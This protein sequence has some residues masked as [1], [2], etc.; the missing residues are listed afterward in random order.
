MSD[1]VGWFNNIVY[2]LENILKVYKRQQIFIHG[3][4]NVGK[5]SLVEK[6]IGRSNLKY[7]F[8]PGLGKF[9][10]QSFD[11]H[12]HKFIVFEEFNIRFFKPSFLKRLLENRS[13]AYPV[14]CGSDNIFAFNG[15]IFFVSNEDIR[16]VC[17]DSG[18][19]GRLK[20]ID[21][22]TPFWQGILK[23]V[24]FVKEETLSGSTFAESCQTISSWET[25]DD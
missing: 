5:S 17:Y 13:Y 23:E 19:L 15:P 10:M 6:L 24:P 21:A 14:K 18:L 2:S 4:T 8:Y 20:I 12:F 9:F 11:I 1:V 22:Y 16:E 25:D 7:V 3:P